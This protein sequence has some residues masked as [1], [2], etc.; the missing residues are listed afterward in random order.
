MPRADLKKG[1][2]IR[3]SMNHLLLICQKHVV[4]S[5]PTNM[6][7]EGEFKPSD[8]LLALHRCTCQ[9]TTLKV[10]LSQPRVLTVSKR[11][12][13]NESLWRL[14][15]VITKVPMDCEMC[16]NHSSTTLEMNFMDWASSS[17]T[18]FTS[19]HSASPD[20]SP[21]TL[22]LFFSWCT[23]QGPKQASIKTK[24]AKS[25]VTKKGVPVLLFFVCFYLFHFH[26]N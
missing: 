17:V 1:I 9:Q 5:I 15:G 24:L 26:L 21:E 7:Q 16:L 8:W 6:K 19:P 12:T 25:L 13:G 20:A 4:T 11:E 3:D 23:I 18:V 14:T 10:K 2:F 22:M